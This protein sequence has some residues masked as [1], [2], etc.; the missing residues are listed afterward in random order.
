MNGYYII[1]CSLFSF[2]FR[3]NLP[4]D[5][6]AFPDFPFDPHLPSFLSYSDILKYLQQYTDY[7]QL[8]PLIQFNTTVVQVKP[9]GTECQ[10]NPIGDELHPSTGSHKKT[11]TFSQWTIT[12]QNLITGQNM[13]ETYDAVVVCNG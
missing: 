1:A 10:P 11:F 5:I 9:K 6:L 13:V 12:T 8:M 3:A 2:Y 7:F 4:K